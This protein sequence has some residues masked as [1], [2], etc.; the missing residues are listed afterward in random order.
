MGGP[1]AS[2]VKQIEAGKRC[3]MCGRAI[4]T[5]PWHRGERKCVACSPKRDA[6]MHFG[7]YKDWWHVSFALLPDQKP[8]ARK[9]TFRDK[10]KLFELARRAGAADEIMAELERTLRAW[11]QGTITL[12]LTEAQVR[13]LGGVEQ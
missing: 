3:Y 12:S 5:P 9:L 10:E 8:L 4:D 1:R 13:A 2:S 7:R 6:Y 11:G